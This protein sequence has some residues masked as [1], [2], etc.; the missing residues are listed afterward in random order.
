DGLQELLLQEAD[1][2]T[3]DLEWEEWVHAFAERFRS[4]ARRHPNCVQ[5]FAG[6]G[7]SSTEAVRPFESALGAFRRAGFDAETS[8]RLLQT[9]VANVI[10]FTLLEAAGQ[11]RLPEAEA[12][13]LPPEEFPHTAE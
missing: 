12:V 2:P 7:I 5:L 9:V 4:V 8:Y 13:D 6:R 10:G 3:G 1:L 11:N